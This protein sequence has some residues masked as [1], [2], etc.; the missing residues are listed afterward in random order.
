MARQR[1]IGYR[2]GEVTLGLAELGM[3]TALCR[4]VVPSKEMA[5]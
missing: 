1:S 2:N 3:A 4:A 5:M